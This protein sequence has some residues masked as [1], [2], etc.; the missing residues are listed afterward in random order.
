VSRTVVKPRSIIARISAAARTVI[1]VS[2]IAS[3]YR[4]FTSDSMT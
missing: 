4:M 1:I 2:G 3:R